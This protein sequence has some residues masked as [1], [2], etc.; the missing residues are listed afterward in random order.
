MNPETKCLCGKPAT[1]I[2]RGVVKLEVED[3]PVCDACSVLPL[4]LCT[5]LAYKRKGGLTVCPH[6][7]RIEHEMY[8]RKKTTCG[9]KKFPNR[10]QY[11][12]G[13]NVD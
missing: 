2:R 8:G 3:V 13:D 10:N 11:E 7:D 5:R 9:M 4:C 12:F 1:Q 6:C